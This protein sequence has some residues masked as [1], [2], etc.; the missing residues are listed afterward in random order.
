MRPN[1]LLQ[2]VVLDTAPS[3]FLLTAEALRAALTPRSRLLILCSPSNPTGAVYPRFAI[4]QFECACCVRETAVQ[5]VQHTVA[6]ALQLWES[7]LLCV[8]TVAE[9]RSAGLSP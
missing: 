4:V 6:A 9:D 1:P 2:A 8:P 3:G 7:G 5:V